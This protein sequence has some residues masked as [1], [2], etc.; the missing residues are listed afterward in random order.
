MATHEDR[1]VLWPG[2]FDA[3]SSR[4][5]GRRV[6]A[7]IAVKNPTLDGLAYAAR[8]AGIRKMKRED[9]T[10]HPARP[11]AR[12]GRLWVL[13]ADALAATGA[14]SKEG[15]MQAV[16]KAWSEQLEA[17]REAEAAAK[18]AGPA[19]GDRGARSQRKMPKGK[20]KGRKLKP[21]ERRKRR[22]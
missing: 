22:K 16:G 15:V 14:A 3:R 20:G 18:A 11:S 6:A 8:A 2:Y 21:S 5:S 9:G 1:L 12:E 13:T 7:D 17:V 10:S 19:K 4:R